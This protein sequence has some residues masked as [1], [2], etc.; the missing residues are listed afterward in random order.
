[1]AE[2]VG[3]GERERSAEAVSNCHRAAAPDDRGGDVSWDL[4]QLVALRELLSDVEHAS[5]LGRSRGGERSIRSCEASDDA[6]LSP[7]QVGGLIH[8][9]HLAA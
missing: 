6:I 4:K 2:R 8:E 5:C 9:Y 1:M 7:E 3:C